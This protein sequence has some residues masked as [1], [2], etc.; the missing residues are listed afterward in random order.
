MCGVGAF[1]YSNRD[2]WCG[3]GF[4]QEAVCATNSHDTA[5]KI[6]FQNVICTKNNVRKKH[7][8]ELLSFM[9]I[10]LAFQCKIKEVSGSASKSH[11]FD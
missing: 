6:F 2:V 11:N 9:I 10:G 4:C 3:V 8:Y 5:E 1:L 7:S